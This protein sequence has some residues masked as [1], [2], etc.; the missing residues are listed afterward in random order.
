MPEERKRFAIKN[1]ERMR[2]LKQ[3]KNLTD[4]EYAEVISQMEMNAAPSFALEDRINRKWKEFESD[5][6]LDDLKINDRLV[7]R[8]LIQ[9]LLQ[10]EDLE[11]AAN[12]L[13]E[14]GIQST[15]VA[16]LREL[17][18]MS[19]GLRKD[20]S[21]MQEDLKITRRHRKGDKEANVISYL[22]DLKMRAKQF[23]EEKMSYIFCPKCGML[24]ATIWTQYPD[25]KGNS[26]KLI[27]RRDLGEG[28]SCNTE[29]IIST[30]ELLEN[31]GTNK[32]DIPESLV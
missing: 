18:N 19:V 1:P 2:N 24:L 32:K 17:N 28:N 8:A 25:K 10:L 31:G 27:C 13:R 16:M 11:Q 9:A 20:I 30:K 26:V 21:G 5:Y 15:S 7:L 4:D 29:V 22:E 12:K 3:Y 23:Y 6:D 14:E